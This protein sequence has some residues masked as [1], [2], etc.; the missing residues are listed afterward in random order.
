MVPAGL[1][2]PRCW[3]R[4]REAAADAGVSVVSARSA[5]DR[6]FA[7]G[8]HGRA[9]ARARAAR[10]ASPQEALAGRERCGAAAGHLRGCGRAR[11]LAAGAVRPGAA[12]GC[13]GRGRGQERSRG[14]VA[15]GSG[16]G[17]PVACGVA[18]Q[19][20]AGRSA[21]P[22]C[23]ARVS[24]RSSTGWMLELSHGHPL[25]L[26]LLVDVLSQRQAERADVA[27]LELGA[28]PDVVGRLVES[29]LAGVP[30]PRHRLALECAAHARLT[31]AGLLGSVFGEREGAELFA[32]LRGLSFMESGPYGAVSAR[33]RARC[34]RRRPALARP[35]G[36]SGPAPA[37]AAHVVE[38]ITAKRGPRARARGR[39][40]HLP[41][42]RQPGGSGVVGL[43]E[44]R[45]RCTRT[46]CAT[47]TVEAI[48]GDGR[49]PRG[50]G[51]G[52]DREAL[53]RAPARG[54]SMSFR[55]RGPEPL[56]F[57]AQIALHAA[58]EAGL[59][60]RS[61]GTGG[62]GARAAPRAA[63][64]GRRGARSAGS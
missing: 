41:A 34:D 25:A 2:R 47:A 51:V 23:A 17:R 3:A 46:R 24:P 48:A 32:W 64:P 63:A 30:S 28:A 10:E 11:G 21:G 58:G 59:R 9:W 54:R 53:A 55:G 35:G 57:A 13:A 15:A 40:S 37:G 52:G 36:L 44:P 18:A 29:F 4:L 62:V 20:R 7:A 27:P 49:A 38:R 19:P 56:G 43:E 31:T 42:S 60:A 14:G 50:A 26:S 61:G 6:A 8:V 39:G 33:P 16:V 22:A 5:R 45:S 1:A 12:G